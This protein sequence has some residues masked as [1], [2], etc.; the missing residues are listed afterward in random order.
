LADKAEVNLR[1]LVVVSDFVRLVKG[2]ADGEEIFL[3]PLP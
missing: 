3:D 1:V 2:D